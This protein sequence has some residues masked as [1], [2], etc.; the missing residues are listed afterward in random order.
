MSKPNVNDLFDPSKLSESSLRKYQV[1]VHPG[2][3]TSSWTAGRRN[4]RTKCALISPTSSR[5]TPT[6]SS[7]SSSNSSAKTREGRSEGPGPQELPT[8]LSSFAQPHH[9]RY[10][11]PLPCLNKPLSVIKSDCFLMM[12]LLQLVVPL[13]LL[14]L[15]LPRL[16]VLSHNRSFVLALPL[17]IRRVLPH[18][19]S[20]VPVRLQKIEPRHFSVLLLRKNNPTE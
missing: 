9:H 10:R 13:Y 4:S 20:H 17:Q 16:Q 6:R 8:D 1:Q 11:P 7:R 3:A 5:S 2:R 19:L 18:G 14:H 15:R 12:Q